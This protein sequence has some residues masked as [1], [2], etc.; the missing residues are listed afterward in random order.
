MYEPKIR[1]DV[2]GSAMD[3]CCLSESMVDRVVF[4]ACIEVVLGREV[5][6]DEEFERVSKW[7]AEREEKI[8]EA[9]GKF[10]LIDV[11]KEE[12]LVKLE[13]FVEEKLKE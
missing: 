4:N 1:K 9:L 7:K 12:E 10:G 8:V 3:I 13:K 6:T 5:R 11:E 2:R